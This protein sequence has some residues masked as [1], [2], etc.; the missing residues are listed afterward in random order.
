MKITR[1]IPILLVVSVVVL[2]GFLNGCDWVRWSGGRSS[3]V[4]EHVDIPA[5]INALLPQKIEVHPFTRI[6][7][8]SQRGDIHGIDLCVRAVDSY[9]DATKAFGK[10]RFELYQ[11]KPA[12]PDPKGS[13]LAVWNE[14]VEAL[15]E[16]RQ[17][18]D[19][20]SR[21]YRFKLA[22]DRSFQ[23]GE[24]FVIV[25]IFQSRYTDRLFAQRVISTGL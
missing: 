7:L 12:S 18:W 10:F 16:N 22:W 14:N 11:F 13:L 2:P 25:V 3:D 8:L 6:G 21:T 24:K 1:V 17:H 19:N 4:T 23:P 5:P 20:I 9:G 15:K